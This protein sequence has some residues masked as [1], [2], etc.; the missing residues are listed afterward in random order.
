[1]GLIFIASLLA[2]TAFE[3][4]HAGTAT[5]AVG[6]SMEGKEMR[7]GVGQSALFATAT[8]S[9]STGAIDA[10]HESLQPLAGGSLLFNMMLGEV[11]PGGVGSGLYGMLVIA[12][13]TVFYLRP[14]GRS[15]S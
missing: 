1:M 10:A 15:N 13:L 3:I 11:T 2:S 12:I 8:T 14:D 4:Q 9:T 6:A 7:F 5:H